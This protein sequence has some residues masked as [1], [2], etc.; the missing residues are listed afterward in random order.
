MRRRSVLFA[1]CPLAPNAWPAGHARTLRERTAS[2]QL[3]RAEE[4]LRLCRDLDP[5]DARQ[6]AR[7]VEIFSAALRGASFRWNPIGE[8]SGVD[9]DLPLS[10]FRFDCMTY[11]ESIVALARARSLDDF[12]EELWQLRYGGQA[13][14]FQ[15]RMHFFSTQWLPNAIDK[16][17]LSDLAVSKTAGMPSKELL[18]TLD[19]RRWFRRLPQNRM[20]AKQLRDLKPGPESEEF[21][22]WGEK[23]QIRRASLRYFTAAPRDGIGPV[24]DGLCSGSVTAVVRPGSPFNEE[25]GLDDPI[26]HLGIAVYANGKWVLRGTSIRDRAVVD[27]PFRSFLPVHP[28]AD[29]PFGYLSLEVL[30]RPRAPTEN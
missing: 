28:R 23:L 6:I 7:R 3:R 30:A 17:A 29:Q 11:V 19:E 27:R 24:T 5:S 22:S 4:L 26:S 8:G 25:A 20:Y 1:S 16:R 10:L 13:P 15:N 2:E 9:T 18:V 14:R 21:A 12:F